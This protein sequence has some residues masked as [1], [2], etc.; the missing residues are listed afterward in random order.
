MDIRRATENSVV[1]P[2]IVDAEK[3]RTDLAFVAFLASGATATRF[4]VRR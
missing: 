1:E 3:G 4:Q 2:R